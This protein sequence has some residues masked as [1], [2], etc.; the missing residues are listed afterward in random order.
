MKKLF[1]VFFVI[2][3]LSFYITFDIKK[4]DID[5]TNTKNSKIT[6]NFYSKEPMLWSIDN[7]EKLAK[8]LESETKNY[9]PVPGQDNSKKIISI[10]KD[11][12]E[13]DMGYSLDK[14]IR[15]LIV[16]M[17][18]EDYTGMDQLNL[19]LTILAPIFLII[20]ENPQKA[21]DE[22]LISEKTY[23]LIKL[24]KGTVKI[25]DKNEKFVN[26]IFKCD[27]ITNKK[28]SSAKLLN[29]IIE[30]EVPD[31]SMED[32]INDHFERNNIS[33]KVKDM[34]DL[35]KFDSK[36]ILIDPNGKNIDIVIFFVKNSAQNF[37]TVDK[38]LYNRSKEYAILIEKEKTVIFN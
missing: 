36:K 31:F 28:C 7:I 15:C 9:V 22:S 13:N 1:F 2:L 26:Y 11:V 35:Y 23:E 10:Y 27:I 21:F 16:S 12:V 4:S 19:L 29:L 8:K 14:T 17:D 34:F 6:D 5:Y 25:D 30:N 33:L 20:D 37:I 38:D 18:S 3:I 32:Y 24:G